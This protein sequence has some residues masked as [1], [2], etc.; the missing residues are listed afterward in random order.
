MTVQDLFNIVIGRLS[1]QPT[2]AIYEA[3]REVTG[4]ITSRILLKKPQMLQTDVTVPLL[5]N[6][7]SVTMDDEFIT[8]AARP[9][10]VG[11]APLSVLYTSDISGLTTPATPRYYQLI[12]KTLH[13]YPPAQSTVTI[14][15]PSYM[16][17]A[18]LAY[19]YPGLPWQDEEL[20][21]QGE[22]DSVF[23]DGCVAIMTSGLS[24]VGN[25]AFAAMIQSQVDA[26]LA[27]KDMLDEQLM[28]DSINGL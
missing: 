19:L 13:V 1:G 26:V 5:E 15:A 6:A 3:V 4:I 12:H 8:L 21:W 24:V 23:I 14:V 22:F 27:T 7:S 16:R 17:P 20:P 18:I 25:A 28:A 11:S 10:I 2:C 9:Y